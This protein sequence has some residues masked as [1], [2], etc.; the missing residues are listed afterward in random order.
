MKTTG[1][2]NEENNPFKTE[3]KFLLLPFFFLSSGCPVPLAGMDP[4]EGRNEHS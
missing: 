1:V 2:Y 3:Q 4:V